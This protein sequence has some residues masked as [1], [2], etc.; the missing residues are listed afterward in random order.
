MKTPFVNTIVIALATATMAAPLKAQIIS[1]PIQ[2]GIMGGVTAPI[3]LLNDATSA[4]WN[5]GAFVNFGVPLVPVSFRLEA[6][7][8][9]MSGNGTAIGCTL[10]PGSDGFCP[11]PIEMRIVDGTANLVYTFPSAVP[12]H[13]YL[14]GGAGAYGER[15]HTIDGGNSPQSVTKFGVNAG[16]GVKVQLGSIDGFVEARYHNVIHGSAIGDY[17][18]RSPRV[19]SLQFVP[20]SAGIIF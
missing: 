17:A 11:E 12:L 15:A 19:K 1:R 7:W 16:A 6:Q 5:A 4:G 8:H 20:I 2:F 13:F 9:H 14:I 3:G 18:I 10:A